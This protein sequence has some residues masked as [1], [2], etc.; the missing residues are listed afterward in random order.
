VV[1]SAAFTVPTK[2]DRMSVCCCVTV[3][4]TPRS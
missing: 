4:V 3:M 1:R 2:A